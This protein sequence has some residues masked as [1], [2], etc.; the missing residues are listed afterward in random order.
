VDYDDT[1]PEV[2]L[3]NGERHRADIVIAVDG[4]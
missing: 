3:K 4:T 1:I 2:T